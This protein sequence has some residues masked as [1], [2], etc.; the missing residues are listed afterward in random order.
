MIDALTPA[1]VKRLP[2]Y[3]GWLMVAAQFMAVMATAGPTTWAFGLFAVSMEEELGWTRGSL[4][5]ALTVRMVIGVALM[6]IMSRLMD[7]PRWPLLIM[8]STS[9]I[10]TGSLMLMA[11]VGSELEY[12]LVFGVIGGLSAAGAGGQLYQAIIP[13]WFIR[14]RGRAVAFGSMGS[15]LGALTAPI[16]IGFFVE[17]LGWR[18]AWFITG[19]IMFVL[20]V[21]LTLLVRRQ[22][23]DIGLLPDGDLPDGDLLT[24]NAPQTAAGAAT[25]G[26]ASAPPLR[27]PAP[28]R[29]ATEES[30]TVREALRSRTTWLLVLATVLL[31]GS[32]QGLGSSWINH[33][34]D[35]GLSRESAAAAVSTYGFFAILG[36][37]SWGL[38][39]ERMHIRKLFLIACV[40]TALPLVLL[41]NVTNL[42]TAMLYAAVAGLTLGGYV[43]VQALIWAN[44]FGR[45]H[46]GAIRGTFA[47]PS[48]VAASVGPWW[49]AFVH[50]TQGSYTWA[51]WAMFIGWI[52]AFGLVFLARP[53]RKAP[54]P[55]PSPAT[56]PAD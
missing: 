28:R 17:A 38:I 13:K 49:I 4:F 48:L 10:Y 29:A 32:L 55:T 41:V 23:E 3:Y 20:M 15:S 47:T 33:Y 52:A 22:P 19:V 34:I 1:W 14:R 35:V 8:L 9:V 40:I 7:N 21:P 46:L 12:Y 44:Y 54:A 2:F 16:Y 25:P 27:R 56:A 39:A 5:G 30:F 11:R 37:I 6:P 18:E 53:L 31:S 42:P 50:D 51:Y 36:R 43:A 26:Q 45:R 24:A